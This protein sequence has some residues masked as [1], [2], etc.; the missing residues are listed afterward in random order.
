MKGKRNDHEDA[1]LKRLR[2]VVPEDVKVTVLADRGFADCDLFD[3]LEAGVRLHDPAARE[4]LGDE[5]GRGEA[6][7]VGLGG[8]GR[9]LCG[10]RVHPA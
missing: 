5:R 10:V 7:G 4:L 1:L 6:E 9:P 2:E 3:L 8:R